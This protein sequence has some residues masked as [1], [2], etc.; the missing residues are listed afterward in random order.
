MLSTFTDPFFE[1]AY[2]DA[3]VALRPADT[4]TFTSG[5]W[6]NV[7]FSCNKAQGD[8]F[9]YNFTAHDHLQ[10]Y[11]L[12]YNTVTGLWGCNASGTPEYV[13]TQA[14]RTVVSSSQVWG[15]LTTNYNFGT[16]TVLVW[17]KRVRSRVLGVRSRVGGT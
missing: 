8:L 14:G 4:L 13:V 2:F 3:L 11:D 9:L 10:V 7:T 15:G 16:F 6:E 5:S 1:S 17:V 12:Y